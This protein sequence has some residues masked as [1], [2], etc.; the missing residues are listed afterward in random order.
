MFSPV[1]DT[2]PPFGDLTK[3][4]S[5]PRPAFVT[6]KVGFPALFIQPG[7]KLRMVQPF[8]AM[9]L[10]TSAWRAAEPSPRRSVS[11]SPSGVLIEV[12]WLEIVTVCYDDERMG[13]PGLLVA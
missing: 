6:S 3:S 5:R 8:A 1:G 4:F 10:A 2:M 7:A 11:P 12:D 13:T 9:A